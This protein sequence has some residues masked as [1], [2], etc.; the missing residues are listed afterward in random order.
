[1]KVSV[2]ITTLNEE[3]SIEKLI[4]SL[5]S[6]TITPD[7]IVIIDGGSSDKTLKILNCNLKKSKIIKVFVKKANRARG[8]NLSVNSAKN[9]IIVMTDA[10]CIPNNNW[11]KRISEPFTD[12]S[13]DVVA[14]FYNMPWSNSFQYIARLY[15]GVV[16]NKFNESF[17]PSTRSAAFRKRVW[18]KVGGFDEKLETGEDTK[19]FSEALKRKLKFVKVKSARVEW[20]EMRNLT[21]RKFVKKIV[22]YAEGDVITKIWWHPSKGLMS[23]NIKILFVYFRY[24]LILILYLL[25]M[26]NVISIYLP[27]ILT[28]LYFLWPIFKW[29]KELRLIEDYFI[30]V[31]VQLVTDMSVMIGFAIGVGK[32]L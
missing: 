23:H 9:E 27:L 13:V 5:L 22:N 19:F 29:K 14:G 25:S 18:K 32:I 26:K 3:R 6:Q 2:C 8:R 30:I 24:A 28:F 20:S 15:L 21:L 1:M 17:I 31:F 10:G 12:N 11:L 16:S 7:E 4:R